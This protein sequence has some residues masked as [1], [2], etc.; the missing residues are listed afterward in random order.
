MV[1]LATPNYT[2]CVQGIFDFEDS[3]ARM[4]LNLLGNIEKSIDHDF[5]ETADDIANLASQVSIVLR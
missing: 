4:K 3:Y 1:P 2:T 5:D